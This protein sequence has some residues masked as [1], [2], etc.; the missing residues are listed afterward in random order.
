MRKQEFLAALRESLGKLP[1]HEVRTTLDFY[2]E[3]I[4]D[5]ME[6]GATEEEAVAA[7]GDVAEIAAQVVA[8]AP[9][10][11]R[12]VAKMK[13]PNRAV[14]IVLA[15]V[16]SPIWVPVALSFLICI[17]CIYLSIWMVI[18]ALWACVA[19]LL[20]CAPI[21]IIGFVW[22]LAKGLPL[23]GLWLLGGG[24]AGSGLG[25]FALMGMKAVSGGLVQLTASFARSVKGLF[26][27]RRSATSDR[28]G[29]ECA[30]AAG[31]RSSSVPPQPPAGY[32]STS[33]PIPAS[34]TGSAVE[35]G[36]HENIA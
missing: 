21:G 34:P 25:L 1:D 31:F 10:I 7:L 35:G 19:I 17:A 30:D 18:V 20:L 22:S 36:S 14:N 13:T 29:A 2:S 12:A 32:R 4:D 11:P 3:A 33:T 26:V 24:L 23:T 27:K 28:E 5:R 15:V 6:E 9:P 8:D 16:L